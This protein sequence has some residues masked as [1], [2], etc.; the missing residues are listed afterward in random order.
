M[1]DRRAGSVGKYNAESPK[2]DS[3]RFNSITMTIHFA[4]LG[5]LFI[6]EGGELE[7]PEGSGGCCG[8]CEGCPQ[9]V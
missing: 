3:R 2:Q 9:A 7:D 6:Y 1:P 5:I 4:H 8:S